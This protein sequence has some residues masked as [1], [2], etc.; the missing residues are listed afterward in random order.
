MAVSLAMMWPFIHSCLRKSAAALASSHT[1]L[2]L[3]SWIL[4]H[5]SL[6]IPAQLLLETRTLV[7]FYHPQPAYPVHILLAPKSPVASLLDL[8]DAHQDFLGDL[9]SSVQKLV[10]DLNL[11]Q[12]GYRLIVNGGSYQEFP[13]LHFHLVSNVT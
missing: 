7:A 1:G 5:M 8:T 6:L 11:E 9:F 12:G 3:I 10:K 4:T 2:G 13:Y